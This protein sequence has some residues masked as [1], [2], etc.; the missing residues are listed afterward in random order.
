[1]IQYRSPL[2]IKL[3]SEWPQGEVNHGKQ[4]TIP[5][6]SN[7]VEEL[8]D[9]YSRGILLPVVSGSYDRADGSDGFDDLNPHDFKDLTD[10][11]AAIRDIQYELRERPKFKQSSGDVE[12]QATSDVNKQEAR[13]DTPDTTD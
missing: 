6:M 1:M 2:E 4:V 8:L 3:M 13:A 10:V 11:D 7:T 5:G 9:K 12:K